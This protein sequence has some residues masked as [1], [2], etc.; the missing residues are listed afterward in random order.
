MSET[1]ESPQYQDYPKLMVHPGFQP[2]TL[3]TSPDDRKGLPG[4][5]GQ[6]VKFPPVTVNNE[7]QEDYHAA[8]GYTPAGKGNP[9]A[10]VSAH[11]SPETPYHRLE[12]PKYVGEIVVNNEDE[13]L[14]AI[15]RNEQMAAAA[16]A[17]RLKAESEAAK[18]AKEPAELEARVDAL[19]AKMDSILEAILAM[20]KPKHRKAEE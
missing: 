3:G 5:I 4:K 11:T 1:H 13:E 20:N 14:A 7:Q 8:Q 6:P 12:Y 16:E 10:F 19:D 9:A 2:A 18:E 15:D 17:K